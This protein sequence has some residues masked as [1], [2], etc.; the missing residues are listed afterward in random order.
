MQNERCPAATPVCQQIGCF[1]KEKQILRCSHPDH[2][3]PFGKS[4]S[5][6]CEDCSGRFD[7]FWSIGNDI[8]DADTI[9]HDQVKR[10]IYN[11]GASLPT[12][13]F[14]AALYGLRLPDGLNLCICAT[15]DATSFCPTHR[16]ID[17]DDLAFAKET[18]STISGQWSSEAAYQLYT[19]CFCGRPADALDRVRVCAGCR[20]PAKAP[21]VDRRAG[22]SDEQDKPSQPVQTT[23]SSSYELC[24]SQGKEVAE[25]DSFS[26]RT[27]DASE[28]VPFE[29]QKEVNSDNLDDDSLSSDSDHESD[30][31]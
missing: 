20:M 1:H 5:L 30:E 7:R 18:E 15:Y 14:H 11:A 19:V 13:A 25:N 17:L 9:R 23:P 29:E 24:C 31:D 3:Q 12:C 21:F 26:T 16:E 4:T 22:I 6:Y 10:D 27:D 8:G 2:D 28:D